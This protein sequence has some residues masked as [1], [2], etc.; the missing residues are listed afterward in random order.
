MPKMMEK[1]PALLSSIVPRA[2]KDAQEKM[3]K[4]GLDVKI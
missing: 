4:N 2:I 3:K 1:M